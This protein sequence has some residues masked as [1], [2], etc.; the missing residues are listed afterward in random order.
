MRGPNPAG[1]RG[2]PCSPWLSH[3]SAWRGLGGVA[4]P[5]DG[6]RGRRVW[7]ERR[8]HKPRRSPELAHA[9][10]L[11]TGRRVLAAIVLHAVGD[12]EERARRSKAERGRLDGR[13]LRRPLVAA[14]RKRMDP[15]GPKPRTRSSEGT[16]WGFGPRA[17]GPWASGDTRRRD[18][19][20]IWSARKSEG[21]GS[22]G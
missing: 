9:P 18:G 7:H 10:R 5:S 19:L 6:G 22:S 17:E 12:A 4:N 3:L 16:S 20:R 15:Q 1:R 11:E 2:E 8:R 13:F 14:R 21:S